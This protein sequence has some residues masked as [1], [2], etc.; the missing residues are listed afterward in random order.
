MGST[1]YYDVTAKALAA[2]AIAITDND[3]CAP[4]S[5][6]VFDKAGNLYGTTNKGGGGDFTTFCQ[7][8]CGTVFKLAPDKDGSWPD[9]YFSPRHGRHA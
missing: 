1:R 8:G 2:A 3:G 5:Y 7:N 6:L 9:S 4:Y